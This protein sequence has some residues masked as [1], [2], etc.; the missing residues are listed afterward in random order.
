MSLVL[1]TS[2]A[3]TLTGTAEANVILGFGGRD[4][5][6]GFEGND[7]ILGGPGND[8][9]FGDN[10][11]GPGQGPAPGVQGPF[12]PRFG[13][14]PGNNLILAGDGNDSVTAGFGAD[15][16]LGG[17]GNDTI[18]GYGFSITTPEGDA[19][20][21]QADGP[22]VLFGGAGHDLLRGGGGND[23]LDGGFG[24]DTL[25]GG[26]GVDTLIG[27]PGDDVFVFGFPAGTFTPDTGVG[28]GNRDLIL[29]FQERQDHLDLSAYGNPFPGSGGN[30]APVFLGTDPFVETAAL[31]VRYQVE[32]GH[33]LVQFVAP[34]G[35]VP[36]GV[37]SGPTGEIELT[38]VH[39]LHA[40]DF[41][42][43]A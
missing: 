7:V 11:P 21:I 25:I 1:G 30:P 42:L 33:T 18:N 15:T 38:G 20:L 27:G 34:L 6:R 43:S 2:H 35:D 29:D 10:A 17:A 40:S 19:G 22:D 31:Q 8:I 23:M 36:P 3:D 12:P 24:R 28:P 9:I 41:I 16:V 37:P 5:I 32:D 39:Y 4:F 26:A 13:G 14:S